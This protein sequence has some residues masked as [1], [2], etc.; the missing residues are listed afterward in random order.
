M[1]I[2]SYVGCGILGLVVVATVIVAVTKSKSDD[3]VMGKILDFLGKYVS[4][5]MTARQKE[6]LEIAK[7][8]LNGEIT[9]DEAKKEING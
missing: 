7:K 5:I 6:L 8:I 9:V 2:V 3:T 1:D 4:M